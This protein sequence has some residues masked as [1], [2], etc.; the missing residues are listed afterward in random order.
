VLVLAERDR[1]T[2]SMM[3]GIAIMQRVQ[4]RGNQSARQAAP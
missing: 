4:R 1:A 2:R 3:D